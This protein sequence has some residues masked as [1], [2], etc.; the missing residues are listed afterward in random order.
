[1]KKGRPGTL[2]TVLCDPA[3]TSALETLLLR[4]TTTLGIR[5]HREQRSCLDRRHTSVSTPFGQIRVKI[6]SLHGEELN[7]MPE[8]E[9]CRAAARAHD[10]PLK[11]VM[12]AA[13]SAYAPAMKEQ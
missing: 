13:I 7:A 10:V 8:F 1:M 12:Q 3:Q 2:V 9:D 6:G 5:K 4:E 11:Q